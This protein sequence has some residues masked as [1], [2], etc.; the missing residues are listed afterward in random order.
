MITN[1]VGPFKMPVI[2]GNSRI[3][4][5]MPEKGVGITDS[6]SHWVSVSLRVNRFP[7]VLLASH[8]QEHILLSIWKPASGNTAVNEAQIHR[9]IEENFQ[10]FTYSGLPRIDADMSSYL[11][12]TFCATTLKSSG[13]IA[14]EVLYVRGCSCDESAPACFDRC[15]LL[16]SFSASPS[17]KSQTS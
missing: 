3:K 12:A 1:P 15:L 2:G 17:L 5:H 16:C 13:C 9:C 7:L 11:C 6:L 14:V 10:L 8:P 4:Q